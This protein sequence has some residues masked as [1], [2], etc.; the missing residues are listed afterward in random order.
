MNDG[1]NGMDRAN[2]GPD[3]DSQSCPCEACNGE[4]RDSEMCQGICERYDENGKELS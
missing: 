1:M 3:Y 4:Y 2:T